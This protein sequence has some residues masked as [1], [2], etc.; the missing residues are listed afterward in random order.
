MK[1]CLGCGALISGGRADRKVCS[2]TCRQRLRR[3][4]KA[5]L[6]P[7]VMRESAR[8]VEWK[9]VRR[10]GRWAK[11]PVQTNGRAASSRDSSTWTDYGS[12]QASKRK[13]WVL[14]NNIGCVDLDRCLVDGVLVGW[15]REVVEEHKEASL[16][17]EVSPSGSG[18][19]IFLPMEPGKGFV[20]RDGRN[21]EVY[22]P[23]SGR[24]ICVTGNVLKV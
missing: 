17:I 4:R 8:W 23:D 20:I 21:I 1:K 2:G 22:P 16:L 24:Y 10:G 11:M 13:G 3:A 6:I 18:V 9:P 7:V 15:A 12:V 14:G 19:H 5:T